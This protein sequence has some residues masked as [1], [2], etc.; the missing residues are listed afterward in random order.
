MKYILPVGKGI[1][2]KKDRDEK[3]KINRDQT[4]V[5][6]IK[7]LSQNVAHVMDNLNWLP[8]VKKICKKKI[9]NCS[10]QSIKILKISVIM[11]IRAA[12]RFQ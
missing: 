7:G 10:D 9:W 11:L 12:D 3:S 1:K 6:K 2:G 5:G 4:L 8:G